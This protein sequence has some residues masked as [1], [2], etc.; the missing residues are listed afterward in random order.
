MVSSGSMPNR[1]A[2]SERRRT[3]SA[4]EDLVADLDVGE[5][6]TRQHVGH[7]GK[8][9]VGDI[10]PEVED[11]VGATMEAVAEDHVG[12]SIQ[13]RFQQGGIVA[14]IILEIGILNDDDVSRA[15][16]RARCARP[17]PSRG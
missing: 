3:T 12:I 5:I 10:V 14:G 17:L 2:V 13:D 4:R 15:L 7:E 6:Q 16:R 9:L 11:S 1:S 8:A